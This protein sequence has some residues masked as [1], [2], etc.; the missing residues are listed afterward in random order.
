VE[1][2]SKQEAAACTTQQSEPLRGPQHPT[3]QAAMDLNL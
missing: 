3:P 1:E 2:A